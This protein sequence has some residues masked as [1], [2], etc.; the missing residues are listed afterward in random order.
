MTLC[1]FFFFAYT[2]HSAPVSQH[3]QLNTEKTCAAAV[4]QSVKLKYAHFEVGGRS[5]MSRKK[6]GGLD[7]D[8]D[9]RRL[10]TLKSIS[11]CADGN[12]RFSM[13]SLTFPPVAHTG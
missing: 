10:L 6:M 7:L 12:H 13:S 9:C 8:L 2:A 4:Q 11:L 5:C 3:A 1:F